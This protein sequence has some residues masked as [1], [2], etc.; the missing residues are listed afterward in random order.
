[1]KRQTIQ[2]SKKEYE[3][4][5]TYSF[6]GQ[7]IV[8]GYTRT[9]KKDLIELKSLFQHLFSHNEKYKSKLIAKNGGKYMITPKN[10]EKIGE[11]VELYNGFIVT[12]AQ[13]ETM[14]SLPDE[15][16]VKTVRKKKND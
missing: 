7:F 5:I 9:S 13:E 2:L 12:E 11:L 6:I 4:L 8:H 1:M 15:K 16:P 14:Y 10:Q 3:Q